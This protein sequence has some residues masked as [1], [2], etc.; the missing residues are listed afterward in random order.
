MTDILYLVDSYYDMTQLSQMYNCQQFPLSQQLLH[1]VFDMDAE[2]KSEKS[3]VDTLHAFCDSCQADTI[4]LVSVNTLMSICRTKYFE[5]V[6]RQ[7]YPQKTVVRLVPIWGSILNDGA[8]ISASPFIAHFDQMCEWMISVSDHQIFQD[9]Q[10]SQNMFVYK[11]SETLQKMLYMQ[12][13]VT[14]SQKQQYRAF[15][16]CLDLVFMEIIRCVWCTGIYIQQVWKCSSYFMQAVYNELGEYVWYSRQKYYAPL[17]TVVCDP[18]YPKI[19]CR[20]K[21]A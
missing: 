12:Y 9:A 1:Q 17:D 3:Y 7:K 18:M 10:T 8:S 14:V 5:R 15:L 13:D 11:V 20:S 6:F 21:V 2:Q 19:T 16:R 4:Y